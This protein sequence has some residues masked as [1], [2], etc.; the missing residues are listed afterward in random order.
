MPLGNDVIEMLKTH[1]CYSEEAHTKYARMHLPVAPKCNIKCNYCNRKY[2]CS[3]ESRPGVTSEVLTP[4]NAI[5]KIRFVKKKIPELKVISI[6]GPGDTLA[7]DESLITLKMVKK[8]FP[9]M[10]LCISTNGLMLPDFAEK[11]YDAGV[12]FVTVTMNGIDTNI[13]E[14]IYDNVLWNGKQLK[15]KEAAEI[16]LK[17]QLEG[18]EKCVKL[19]MAVK[20]NV[21]LIPGINDKHIPDLVKKVK[22]MGAYIVNILP[23]IPVKDTKFENLEAPSPEMRKKLLDICSGDIKMMRHCR[24][25]RADAIGLLGEDRS[26]EFIRTNPC[27]L[28]CKQEKDVVKQPEKRSDGVIK[29]AVATESGK[30]VDSGFGNAKKFSIYSTDGKTVKL[31]KTIE[32]NDDYRIYGKSHSEHLDNIVKKLEDCDCVIVKEIGPYPSNQL[33]KRGIRISVDNGDVE[34]AIKRAYSI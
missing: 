24:Q 14:K 1:P 19:G 11:L 3:N 9:E 10:L 20:I 6:A 28:T 31:V 8:E 33:S 12:R 21:V 26:Q 22:E 5:E 7:N 23:L 15:G 32:I 25:C 17:R 27:G 30:L 2:D 34:T 18:I 16:L 13:T 29:V 4:E